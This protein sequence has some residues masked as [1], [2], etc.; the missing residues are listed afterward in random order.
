[1]NFVF[2]RRFFIL[3]AIGFV[4]LSLSWNAP[5]L[6]TAVFAGD[7]LLVLLAVVDYFISRK[8]P[9]ELTTTRE[10]S[11]RFAIGDQTEARLKI[12]NRSAKTFLLQ[13]KDEFPPEMKLVETKIKNAFRF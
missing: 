5:G 11:K 2:S 12:E 1:M 6:R 3:L 8:L 7:A 10:F 13:I 9:A 4:P